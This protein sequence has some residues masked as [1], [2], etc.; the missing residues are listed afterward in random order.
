MPGF[1]EGV[2]E[3]TQKT[4]DKQSPSKPADDA[5]KED[6]ES[7]DGEKTD[8]EDADKDDDSDEDEAEEETDPLVSINLNDVEMK[9]IIQ[10]I[11]DWTGKPVIPTTEDV[12]KLKLTIYASEKLPRSKALSL[13]YDAL[14]VKGFITEE[15]GDRIFLKPIAKAKFGSVP[16]LG[17]D[18][19]LARIEDKS[20]IVEKFFKLDNYSSAK[21]VE[22]ITPLI[23]EY[24]HVTG[25][26]TTGTIAVIDTVENL[27]RIK[28]IIDQLDVPESEQ[29]T[30]KYFEIK[31]GDP[32]EIVQVLELIL[33]VSNNNRRRG[34]NRSSGR[35]TPAA[36]K[37]ATQATSVVI[38]STEIPATLIPIPKHN[39]II[40]RAAKVDMKRIAEWIEKLDVSE[41]IEPEQ[42]II[43]VDFVDPMQVVRLVKDTLRDM[44]G[45][46]LRTS[47]VVEALRDSKQI[48]ILGSAENRKTIERLIAE[49]DLPSDDI[50]IDRTFKLKHADA[51]QIKAN[52]EGLYESIAGYSSSYSYSN[53]GRSS[54]SREVKPEDT[55]KAIAYPTMSQVTV[56]AT[57]ENMKKVANQ[58]AEWDVPLDIEKDQYRLI[59]LR[60]SDPVKMV[61]LLS[62]LF[63]EESD[64]SRGN[65]F[66]M[67]FGDGGGSE[68][69]KKIVG[70]LYGMLTFE[71]VPDTKKIIVISKIPQAYD[72]IEKL[73][74]DLDSQEMAEVPKVITLK[75]ADAEDLCDQLN[76][77]LNEPG[78]TATIRRKTRGLLVDSDSPVDAE[79]IKTADEDSANSA[80]EIK[81]WWNQQRRSTDEMPT[82]NLIGKIRFIPVHRSKAILVLAP[83]EY[84]GAIEQMIE[85]LDQPGKQV[86][87]KVVI[88]E[89]SHSKMTSL[90]LLLS[91]NS[92]AL[93][94]IGENAIAAL[95]TLSGATSRGSLDVS[96]SVT[97]LNILIDLL[98]KNVDA[99]VLNQP[100]LWTKDNEEAVFIKAQNIAFIV[101]DQRDTTNVNSLNQTFEYRDV[102]VTLRVRPNI[103]PERAVDITIYL[104]ISTVE[105][106]DI[107]GQIATNKLDTTTNVIVEDGAT[108]M[109]GGILFQTDSTV[110]QK[111]P[112]LGDLPLVGGLFS[113]DENV[114]RNNELLI[115]IT[116]Y[117][118]DGEDTK[119][120]TTEYLDASRAKMEKMA[121]QMADFF[122]EELMQESEPEADADITES[123]SSR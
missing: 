71:P 51:D 114:L 23:A 123:P 60:N 25:I 72:V 120:A 87:I 98:E 42:T 89:I 32:A 17:F 45:S 97:D 11:G 41:T 90:G 107:N 34:N 82:S 8:S 43:Q 3:Q 119:P 36:A 74:K 68:S 115:F 9:S 61:D 16:T 48:V 35:A 21:M 76:A 106:E 29:I 84:L 112:L 49:I 30:E 67:I 14:R 38:S 33:G 78:T 104:E 66:R 91:S 40:V 81:P 117:V 57:E 86:M 64:D 12:M 20:Q 44:P 22:V 2:A 102:G 113:H 116:P 13:I 122:D 55:V 75:Y 93:G 39:W 47:V 7:D 15:A 118:I 54:R 96:Y 95:T 65:L 37:G 52:I 50:F 53:R 1:K 59:A 63:S 24:G 10:T 99:K 108:I 94:N 27:M 121:G 56:I 46:K 80:G 92:S 73:I 6:E 109:L 100:T 4:E 26:E 18:E 69:K 111:I 70:S 31:N 77:I 105:A 101:A 5:S 62:G 110:H 85:E 28:R 83:P 88:V 103:T 58:I 79:G 19:A